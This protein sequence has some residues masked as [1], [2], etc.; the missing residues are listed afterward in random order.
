FGQ[1]SRRADS[2]RRPSVKS[3]QLSR[4]ILF[5]AFLIL[6]SYGRASAQASSGEHQPAAASTGHSSETGRTGAAAQEE[7]A[8]KH[9]AEEEDP[10][11]QFKRSPSVKWL[12]RKTGL[13]L[14][15]AYWLSFITNFLIVVVLIW[16]GLK[17]NLPAMLRNRTQDVQRAIQEARHASED[18]G[19]R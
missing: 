11:A 6:L 4:T 16:L 15:G 18:A 8:N 14:D 13:S 5:A 12:A 7:S 2:G 1:E 17:S 9:E 10:A 3:S 19:R